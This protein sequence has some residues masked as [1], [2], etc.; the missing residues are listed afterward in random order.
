MTALYASRAPLSS[1][2]IAIGSIALAQSPIPPPVGADFN[3]G[4]PS[5]WQITTLSSTGWA[6]GSTVGYYGSGGLI[7]DCGGC[8]SY[9]ETVVWSPWLDLS[10]EPLIDI[11][12]RCAI[13]GSSM[14]VPPPIFVMRDGVGGTQ[15]TYRYGFA[16]LIPPPDEV[17]PSTIDPMPPLDLGQVQWVDITYPFNAGLDND[18]VRLGIGTGVPLGGYALVDDIGIG[19][20]PTSSASAE[21]P[22]PILMRQ[23]DRITLRSTRPIDRWELL[24]L[25]GR[26]LIDG[27][28]RTGNE[29]C[30]SLAGLASSVYLVRVWQGGA[31]AVMR[32]HC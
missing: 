13:I 8:S 22:A 1:V 28:N 10:E 12:F 17:I 5:D 15:Y 14:M 25:S 26:V 29:A 32:I 16:D 9:Q 18:S 31:P 21:M 19:G 23:G 4:V 3:S 20:L 24:D 27:Q 11:T 30:I 2:C 6:W 7:M